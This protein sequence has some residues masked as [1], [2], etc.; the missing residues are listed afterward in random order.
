MKIAPYRFVIITV[1]LATATL[2]SGCAGGGASELA[3]RPA[4]KPLRLNAAVRIPGDHPFSVL[5]S[6]SQEN[7]APGGTAE[8]HS[9]AKPTGEAVASAA[10]EKGGTA[11]ASF[12]L[13]GAFENETDQQVDVEISAKYHFDYTLRSDARSRTA[14]GTL[15]LHLYARDQH[16]RLLRDIPV[17]VQST[18]QGAASQSGDQTL[19]LTVTI[20]SRDSLFVFFGGSVGVDTMKSSRTAKAELKISNAELSLSSKA[21]PPVTGSAP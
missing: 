3:I 7:P 21:A 14:D 13:G 4:T 2:L 17:L 20:G 8:S 5:S 19:T 6:P 16:N 1:S 12:Q 9:S 11:S 15:S 18:D 10:V